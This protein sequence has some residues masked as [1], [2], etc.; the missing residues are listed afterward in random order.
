MKVVLSAVAMLLA[1]TAAFAAQA[2]GK[3]TAIDREA[4]TITLEDGKT[5]KLPGEVDI[6][7]LVEGME[8]VIAYDEV[9]GENLIT[10][11]SE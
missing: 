8:I 9:G 6:S 2:E 3:I 4:Q 5:Y 1:S 11:L 10:D 7:A